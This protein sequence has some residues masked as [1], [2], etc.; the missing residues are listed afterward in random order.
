[1]TELTNRPDPAGGEE[2]NAGQMKETV[3]EG[4]QQ[5][6]ERVS[7]TTQRVGTQA[8]AR[9]R[10]QVDRRS[11]QVGEQA[12]TVAD[13]MRR[14]GE[15]LRG[16]GQ[17]GPARFVEGAADRVQRAG[18]YLHASSADRILGDVEDFARRQ[19]WAV[20][21]G[22]LA[23]GFVASRVLKASSTRRYESSFGR[24]ARM[25]PARDYAPAHD[26]E[27]VAPSRDLPLGPMEPP[28]V[29]ADA[30]AGL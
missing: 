23:I 11:T 28:L 20:A 7:E 16:D 2:S 27:F 12:Q 15:Q 17:D 8:G 18:S 29:G 10:E 3:Q 14:T 22:G 13:A 21:L 6:K 26:R 5:A 24:E 1:M 30:D 4:V 9:V 19:P 25:T